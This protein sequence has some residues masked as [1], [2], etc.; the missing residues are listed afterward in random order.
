[1]TISSD[2]PPGPGT[3]EVAAPVGSHESGRT[4]AVV[5]QTKD[6][7]KPGVCSNCFDQGGSPS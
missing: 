6:E 3:M 7:A 1:M 2:V 4:F 5:D